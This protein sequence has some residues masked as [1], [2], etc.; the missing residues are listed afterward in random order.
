MKW[1]KRF[2]MFI[3][4]LVVM[5]VVVSSCSV[6]MLK[7]DPEW[8]TRPPMTPQMRDEAVARAQTQ[9]SRVEDLATSLRAYEARRQ[10]A[11]R[12]GTTLPSDELPKPVTLR[13]TEDELNAVFQTFSRARGWDQDLKQYMSDP[14]IILQKDNLILGG[15]LNELHVVASAYFNTSIDDNGQFRLDLVRVLGGKLPLPDMI[16]DKY[17]KTLVGGLQR[18]LPPLQNAAKIDP[19]GVPNDSTVQASLTKLLLQSIQHQ[20]SEPVF[21][22]PLLTAKGTVP[23][24]LADVQVTEQHIQMTIAPMS[25][26]ERSEMLERLK[27][28]YQMQTAATP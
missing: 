23:V 22:L 6:Y 3:A 4:C 24:R 14:T 15:R 13:L 2:L 28:P 9:F 27:M 25:E 11:I 21:F 8:A 12:D 18:R 10:K 7:K 17:R 16:F 1:F 19:R 20:P 5:L 26:A